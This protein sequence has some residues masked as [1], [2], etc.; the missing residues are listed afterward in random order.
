MAESYKNYIE[1]LESGVEERTGEKCPL[2]LRPIIRAAAQN[3]VLIDKCIEDFGDG[4]VKEEMGSMG[5]TK[6][7]PHPLL[8]VYKEAQRCL[9]FQLEK[10]GITYS[11]TPSKITENAKKSSAKTD[12]LMAWA[13]T[14]HK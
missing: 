13:A 12:P 7:T 5:Q 2:W 10:I 11:A 4:L 9:T 8:S 6:E 14:T 3:M 1:E